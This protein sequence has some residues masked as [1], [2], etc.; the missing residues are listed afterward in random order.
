[1]FTKWNKLNPKGY[2]YKY[3]YVDEEGVEYNAYNNAAYTPT[4]EKSLED[5]N[6]I[7]FLDYY[8]NTFPIEDRARIF[9]YL[10]NANTEL[11]FEF[12]STHIQEK[13]KMLCKMIRLAI[14]SLPKDEVMY[15]E[16]Y[17]E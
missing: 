5:V 17:L 14:P 16:K 10:M 4:D 13:A 12:K 9:E 11:S 7:Y 15:W 3:S 8:S 6:N 1:M 2:D